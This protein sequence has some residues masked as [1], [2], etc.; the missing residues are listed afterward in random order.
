MVEIEPSVFP[1]GESEDETERSTGRWKVDLDAAGE[2]GS[3]PSLRVA[4]EEGVDCL[5]LAF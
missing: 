4:G 3:V 1:F 2:T 5:T